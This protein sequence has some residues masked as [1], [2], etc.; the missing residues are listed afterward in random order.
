MIKIT[1]NNWEDILKKPQD[2]ID[3][4]QDIVLVEIIPV[5]N[6]NNITMLMVGQD[7]MDGSY[8]IVVED[9]DTAEDIYLER[10]ETL[11]A[12][13]ME[14]Y[15]DL[16]RRDDLLTIMHS[17]SVN[18]NVSPEF[19]GDNGC[20]IELTQPVIDMINSILEQAYLPFLVDV[21]IDNGYR[22]LGN[23]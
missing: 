16:K 11:Y 17:A 15:N 5:S 3:D 1:K 13:F 9:N 12:K 23:E 18:A 4:A 14:I 22:K 6:P 7:E 19:H 8:Y 20:T 21:V 10:D 2:F